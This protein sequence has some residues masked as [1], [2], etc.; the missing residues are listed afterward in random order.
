MRSSGRPMPIQVLPSAS[1][2][3]LLIIDSYTYP[4]PPAEFYT[5]DQ[6]LPFSPT[7]FP[8]FPNLSNAHPSMLVPTWNPLPSSDIP[9]DALAF[10]DDLLL[11]FDTALVQAQEADCVDSGHFPGVPW[12]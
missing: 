4:Q 11:D 3:Q 2:S 10:G 7:V 5:C 6:A 9:F 12:L 8:N 1:Q